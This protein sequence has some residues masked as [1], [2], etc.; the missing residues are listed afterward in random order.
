[1]SPVRNASRALADVMERSA[2]R[3]VTEE[4]RRITARAQARH[5]AKGHDAGALREC[6]DPVCA[7]LVEILEAHD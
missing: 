7:A 2:R 3:G 6:P 1:M 4:R 5:E